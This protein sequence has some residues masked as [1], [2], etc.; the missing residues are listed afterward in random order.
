M[1]SVIRSLIL[2]LVSDKCYEKY[3]YEN[4]FF[5]GKMKVAHPLLSIFNSFIYS[6]FLL[7]LQLIVLRRC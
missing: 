2:Q 5:D 6:R 4:D 1:A 3:F 7:I